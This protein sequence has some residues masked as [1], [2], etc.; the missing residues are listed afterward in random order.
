M[1]IV[2][3]RASQAELGAFCRKW[4]VVELGVFGSVAKGEDRP[5]SDLDVIVSFGDGA[6]WGLFDLVRMEDELSALVGRRVD[7][8]ERRAVETSPNYIRRR[9]ILN[10]VVPLYAE[11]R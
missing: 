7:L 4:K 9:S 6:S 3:I 2:G 5:D 10:S 11:P 8:V 1:A